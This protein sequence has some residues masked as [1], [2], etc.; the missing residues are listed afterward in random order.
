MALLSL[1]RG[2]VRGIW[3]GGFFTGDSERHVRKGFG[4]GA[5]LSLQRLREGNLEG[6]LPILRAPRHM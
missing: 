2:F 3:R 6:G 4:G 5:S 1:C